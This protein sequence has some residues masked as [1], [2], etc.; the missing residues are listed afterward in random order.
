MKIL[1]QKATEFIGLLS[2]KAPVPGG[3]GAA[4]TV[5]AL[6]SALGMMVANLTVGK[7]KYADVEEDFEAWDDGEMNTA[8]TAYYL[9]VQTR[10][11]K[12]LLEVAE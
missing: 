9:D 10:V 7:K 5:G 1:D 6:A 8:E 4:A 2:S 3:G 12:K 11:S